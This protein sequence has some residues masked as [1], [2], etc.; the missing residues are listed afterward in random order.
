MAKKSKTLKYNPKA[1][2]LLRDVDAKRFRD[3]GI[4]KDSF[5]DYH[6]FINVSSTQSMGR[7]HRFWCEKQKR[8]VE[9]MSDGEYNAYQFLIWKPNVIAVQEQ[10][11]LNPAITFEIATE[12]KYVHPYSYKF[13]IH[14]IMSTDFLV[15]SEKPDGTII[16]HA[17][18]YKPK[19][20][21]AKPSRTKQKLEIESQFWAQQNIPCSVLTEKDVSKNW[22]YTLGFCQL[23][24]DPSLKTEDLTLFTAT[25]I[26]AHKVQP[27]MP[28][29][30]LIMH[31]ASMINESQH[32]AER[33]FKNSVLR[34]LLSLDP[35]HRVR[36]NEALMLKGYY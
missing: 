13:H 24:Y 23:H 19:F 11:A 21:P 30:K 3:W 7:K 18:P 26:K 33:L 29:R 36:L 25:L 14:H 31:T 22:T 4:K 6:S 15:S 28:L 10:Y 5:Q 16:K 35:K 20:E 1:E 17:Y 9:L 2:L 32:V 12:L 34:G 8:I 27:W